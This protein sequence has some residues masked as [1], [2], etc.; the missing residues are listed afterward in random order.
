M[1]SDATAGH[2]GQKIAAVLVLYKP[3]KV[4]TCCKMNKLCWSGTE[5]GNEPSTLS[6]NKLETQDRSGT[7]GVSD[8]LSCLKASLI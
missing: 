8:Q 5:G 4:G 7:D 1:C 3:G 2:S 6:G